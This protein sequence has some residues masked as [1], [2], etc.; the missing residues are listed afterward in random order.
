MRD[1]PIATS[2]GA[3]AGI[4]LAIALVEED[5]GRVVAH[6]IARMLVVYLRRPGSQA[7]VSVQLSA[8]MARTDPLQEVQNRA[9]TNTCP[10]RRWRSGRA[11]HHAS[12][13]VRPAIRSG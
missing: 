1:G 10:C 6:E 7:Q 2:A 4:Y 8:Q 3:T 12:S 13:L 9:A 5:H 11:C